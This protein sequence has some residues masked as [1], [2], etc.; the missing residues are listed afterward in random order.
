MK[1]RKA[2]SKLFLLKFTN[3]PLKVKNCL[4]PALKKKSTQ[5]IFDNSKEIKDLFASYDSKNI[6]NSPEHT[7]IQKENDIFQK[8][9]DNY[10]SIKNLNNQNLEKEDKDD[11][12]SEIIK[13]YTNKG[14]KVPNIH[15]KNIFDRNPL[16]LKGIGL[17][18]YYEQI[19]LNQKNPISD[20]EKNLAFLRKTSKYLNNV[21]NLRISQKKGYS[22][23]EIKSMKTLEKQNEERRRS[24]NFGTRKSTNK[25]HI[26]CLTPTCFQEENNKLNDE[27]EK[28]DSEEKEKLKKLNIEIEDLKK[29]YN[30]V[31]NDL[32]ENDFSKSR[33]FSDNNSQRKYQKFPKIEKKPLCLFNFHDNSNLKSNIFN[34][35]ENNLFG[36]N[37]IEK[38]SKKNVINFKIPQKPINNITNNSNDLKQNSFKIDKKERNSCIDLKQINNNIINNNIVQINR[39]LIKQKTDYCPDKKYNLANY[40]NKI[41]NKMRAK[42]RTLA[43]VYIY[44]SNNNHQTKNKVNS[45]SNVKIRRSSFC[46][47]GNNIR[48]NF[49]KFRTKEELLN[50]LF[51]NIN[52]STELGEN[53]ISIFKK[54]FL[55]HTKIKEHDLN[56][57][58]KKQYEPNDFAKFCSS[59]ERKVLNQNTV[60]IWKKNFMK[61]DKLVERKNLFNKADK[62]DYCILHLYHS[63]V[64]A[65]EGQR[66][67]I[68]MK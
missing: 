29:Y 47:M 56:Q 33:N 30:Y 26:H 24:R 6:L 28:L 15:S 61:L 45:N 53:F 18:T 27:N 10:Q 4:N 19:S 39:S 43:N 20:E 65:I 35:K 64:S 16:N 7:L 59:I 46:T 3:Y 44:D 40:Q 9:M 66:R 17:V 38:I 50:Y 2:K 11:P 14:Y 36:K 51:N 8:N 52:K 31:L 57:Y 54:Y 25:K 55:R 60:S 5:N 67:F 1:M 48:N 34:I 49:Y 42:H 32:N 37:N 41:T 22:S 23:L 12:I 68:E 63:F 62:I 58:I 21:K 13:Q